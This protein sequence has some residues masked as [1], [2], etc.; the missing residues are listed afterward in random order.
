M[1]FVLAIAIWQG[2]KARYEAKYTIFSKMCFKVGYIQGKV[3][4]F[5]KDLFFELGINL[6]K[7]NNP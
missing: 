6:I 5:V 4:L 2:V 3:K 7:A 1:A